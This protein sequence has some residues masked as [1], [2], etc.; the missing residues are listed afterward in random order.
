MHPPAVGDDWVALIDG[1][2]PG[3]DEAASWVA[4]PECGAVVVFTGLVRN[5]ASGRPGVNE[6]EYEAYGSQIEPRFA[7]LVNECRR[8]WPTLGRVA[9]WHRRGVLRVGEVSVLIAVSSAHRAE[10]FEAARWCIDTLKSTSPIWKRERWD[11]GEDWGCDA[12]AIDEVV[13]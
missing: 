13:R 12:H 7:A 5:H 3:Q 2:L 6:I 1:P 9:V 10:A 11:G 8:R 4:R